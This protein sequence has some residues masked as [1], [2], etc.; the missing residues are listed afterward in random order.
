MAFCWTCFS[1]F[2]VLLPW[3][4]F[5]P[6]STVDDFDWATV[7]GLFCAATSMFA[8]L[9]LPAVLFVYVTHKQQIAAALGCQTTQDDLSKSDASVEAV[10]FIYLSWA[11][12]IGVILP[13]YYSQTGGD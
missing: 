3:C 13:Y 2:G 6:L 5:V 12:P 8:V 4:F 1:C 9:G 11:V 10:I 7:Q